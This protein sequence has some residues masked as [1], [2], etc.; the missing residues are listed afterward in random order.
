[1][2]WSPRPCC[3]ASPR[4]RSSTSEM[5]AALRQRLVLLLLALA[6]GAWWLARR[7]R[8]LGISQGALGP[9]CER[10]LSVV[11]AGLAGLALLAVVLRMVCAWRG[12]QAGFARLQAGFAHGLCVACIGLAAFELVSQRVSTI[13]RPPERLIDSLTGVNVP[14]AALGWVGHPS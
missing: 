12:K 9:A 13:P 5:L 1:S 10:V 14:H 8:E 7:G 2:A 11:A 3:A 4:L 6:G